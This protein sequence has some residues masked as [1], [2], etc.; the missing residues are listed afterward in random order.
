MP[1]AKLA[2]SADTCQAI[3]HDNIS[4]ASPGRKELE[5]EG[6]EEQDE[7]VVTSIE[8]NH[9]ETPETLACLEETDHLSCWGPGTF[10][11][12]QTS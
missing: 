5:I 12:P 3:I 6:F 8:I 7:C 2:C 4:N 9:R 10:P 1:A 11:R